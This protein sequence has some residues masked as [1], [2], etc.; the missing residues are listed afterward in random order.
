MERALNYCPFYEY[1][2]AQEKI[3]LL[4]VNKSLYAWIARPLVWKMNNLQFNAHTPFSIRN[5]SLF[6]G[7]SKCATCGERMMEY[8]MKMTY[9]TASS[10]ETTMKL[11]QPQIETTRFQCHKCRRWVCYRCESSLDL[12]RCCITCLSCDAA[13]YSVFGYHA[14]C[15]SCLDREQKRQKQ[16]RARKRK[17]QSRSMTTTAL[18]SKDT[19]IIL[20]SYMFQ[21]RKKKARIN[22]N[23]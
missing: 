12:K 14:S 16:E 2:T 23:E 11:T 4:A 15:L 17:R 20:R 9:I 8:G 21:G 19:R 6:F 10:R 22:N 18:S 13:N 7:G 3:R 1:L 5:I